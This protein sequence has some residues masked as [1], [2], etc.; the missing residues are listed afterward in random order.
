M[1]IAMLSKAIAVSK[2]IGAKIFKNDETGIKR[3]VCGI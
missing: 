2:K 3:S 1:V